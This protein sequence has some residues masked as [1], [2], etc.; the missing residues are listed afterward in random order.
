MAEI[1]E[2]G[3]L[4][5]QASLYVLVSA[6]TVEWLLHASAETGY[7]LDRLAEISVEEAALEYAKE[8]KLLKGGDA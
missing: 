1:Y 8:R 2:D 7:S 6:K 4:K 5:G 3:P